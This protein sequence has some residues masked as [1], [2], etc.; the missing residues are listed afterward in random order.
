MPEDTTIVLEDLNIQHDTHEIL[1]KVNFSLKKGDFIYLIGKTASGKS[2]LIRSLYAELPVFSGSG[3]VVGYELNGI[4]RRD[5]PYLRRKVGVVFQDFQ[6]LPDRTIKANL[7]FVLKATGWSNSEQI[8]ERVNEVLSKVELEDKLLVLPHQ[9]SGGEQ[10]RIVIA[11]ALLNDPELILADE[12]TGNLD[13]QTSEEI[14][15]L[16]V[17]ISENGKTVVFATHNYAL[18]N[19]FPSPVLRCEDGKVALFSADQIAGIIPHY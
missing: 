19:K 6:L 13:P 17:K 9:L 7:E 12:P 1:H 14:L 5:V 18:L 4:K 8:H 2:S 16:L 10:Q 11:R 3:R 15:D